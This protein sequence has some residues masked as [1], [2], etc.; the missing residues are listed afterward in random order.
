MKKLI[1]F[2]FAPMAL[3][4]SLF[5]AGPASIPGRQPSSS[6]PHSNG[7]RQCGHGSSDSRSQQLAVGSRRQNSPETGEK[8]SRPPRNH[9]RTGDKSDEDADLRKMRDFIAI[10]DRGD[11]LSV[12]LRRTCPDRHC[13]RAICVGREPHADSA[14]S[15]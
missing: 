8:A 5:C 15:A 4:I 1:S 2:A 6:N 11:R 14:P 9:H 7:N 10:P 13:D 3:A 12:H